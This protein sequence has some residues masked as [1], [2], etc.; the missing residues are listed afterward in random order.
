MPTL[1]DRSVVLAG[2]IGGTKTNLGLFLSG[3][4]RPVPKIIETYSSRTAPDL[5]SI[6]D[7]FLDKHHAS[8]TGACLG[9]A[10]PVHNGRCKTTN[11]PWEVSETRIKRRF[12]W[13]RVRLINDLTA[14]ARAIPLLSS[15][16]MI[17]INSAKVMGR[18][19]KGLVAPGTGLGMALLIWNE[20]GYIPI[21]SE[22]GHV[23]F[24]PNNELEAR[25]W[26]Y[27][28]ER[29]GHVSIERVLSG[30]GLF[31]IY[32]WLKASGR[33]HEPVWL[34]ENIK[35]MDPPRAIAEAAL[36]REQPLCGEALKVFISIFG[37]VA[38]NLAL[39]GLTTGGIYLGGGI[40][41]KVLRKS[42]E[43]IFMRAF[44]DK[45]R[46]KDLLKKIPVRVIRNDKAAL[47]GAAFCA[48]TSFHSEPPKR[49]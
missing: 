19:N 4:R 21:P 35:A 20:N 47:I 31:N 37:A 23:D 42:N 46:F 41:P 15:R 5:E 27:L 9:I 43:T 11:L 17:S 30:Q 10:G 6:I 1:E 32:S 33:Y 2:D 22:G 12:K 25:L 34:A 48:L 26:R 18:R 45:G 3:K 40:S 7:R 8:I 14:T 44:A 24:G 28:H 36:D 39:T 38:G 29:F 13:D 16:E 49:A